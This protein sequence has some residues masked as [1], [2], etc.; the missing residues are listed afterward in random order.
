M[1]KYHISADGNPRICTAAEGQCPLGAEEMHFNSKLQARAAYEAEL[2]V[3]T[4]ASLHKKDAPTTPL[5][6]YETPL[7]EPQYEYVYSRVQATEVKS[8]DEYRVSDG[9]TA[10]VLNVKL[11]TKNYTFTVRAENGKEKNIVGPLGDQV[12]INKKVETDESKQLRKK[13]D[14]ER[15]LERTLKNYEVKQ[16]AVLAS[17]MLKQQKGMFA[18]SWDFKDIIA[19][20]AE[21]TVKVEYERMVNSVKSS[22]EG[23]K[24]GFA[25]EKYPYTRA[26][27]ILKEQ[28]L[29]EIVRHSAR[30]E[31]HSTSDV[32][33]VTDSEMMRAKAQFLKESRWF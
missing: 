16:P 32:S 5:E 10:K 20:A 15:N 28:Y 2:E 4:I 1:A 22:I 31:S 18:T 13:V 9:S 14:F 7:F 19:A 30:G 3:Q 24:E 23:G 33:N 29:D 6:P 27:D 21:D 8:G 25:Q 26:Y 12:F 11:G 17:M